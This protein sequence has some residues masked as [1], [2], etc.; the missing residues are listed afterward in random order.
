MAPKQTNNK[1]QSLPF[2]SPF[3]SSGFQRPLED[4]DMD[5]SM[6]PLQAPASPMPRVTP[7]SVHV[8]SPHVPTHDKGS[9]G[10]NR[11]DFTTPSI[12]SYSEGQPA[13]SNSWDGSYHALSVF[14]TESTL[15]KDSEMIYDFLSR[16]RKFIKYHPN[17]TENEV[18]P[19]VKKLW[20]L[21]DIIY[22]MKWNSI[23]FDKDKN[24]TIRKCVGDHIMPYY[25]QNQPSSESSNIT[26]TNTSSSLPSVEAAPPPTVNVPRAPPPLNKNVKSTTKKDPKPSN[27]KKSYM[28]ASKSNLLRIEDIVRVKEAFPALSADEVGKVLKIKNSIED[29]RKPKINMTTRGPS[30][31]EVIILMAKNIAELIVNSAHIHITNVNK[32]LRNSKSDIVADFIHITNNG[33]IITTSKP[34][35]DLNL[36]TIENYL[37]NI[38]SIDSN[39]I[40][41]PRL[42]KS[43]SY[44]KIIGLPYKINQDIISPDF[45]EGV[46][47]ET[48]LFKDA[49]LASKPCVIK[50]SPK[51]D[52]AVVWVD[53]WDSQSGSLAKNIINRQFNIGRFIATVKGTNMNPGVLQCKNCWKWGHLTLSCCSHISR[54]AKCNGA[55][56][57]EHHREKAWCCMENKKV[58][59][60]A[61]K[62]GEPC[63]HVFKCMN[64]KGDYQADSYSCLYWRNHFNQEW[65]SRKQQELF[66][67]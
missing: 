51:S 37:K 9:N 55:H 27:L 49:V 11:A 38:Q 4:L 57:T 25:M 18:K 33:I 26:M 20:R 14:G 17:P 54:C 56:T 46:L 43:K 47:K 42:P 63:P 65:H 32:C 28:Q 30:R 62:E 59:H 66:R 34:A 41:S 5:W 19:V 60:S 64:C 3:L 35:N 36:S 31:K 15:A 10:K 67:K 1:K 44:M 58:N 8:P 53:I 13:I 24:L 21:I 16:L 52:M 22:A 29:N 45:I 48:H 40:K 2:V 50:A 39:L 12:L 7:A 6:D 23:P 61:T